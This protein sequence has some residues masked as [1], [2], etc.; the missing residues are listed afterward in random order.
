VLAVPL[1]AAIRPNILLLTVDDMSADSVGVFGSKLAGTTPNMDK[2]AS[3][4]L[5][6]A[7]AH[8]TVGNCMP[9]RNVMLSGLYSH[10][11]KV[12]GFYQVKN[13]G[14]PHLV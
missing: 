14:W 6:F 10:N 1:S 5:R 7:H 12:E 3:Q 11:N 9:C 2:L 8:V 13:P 4:S